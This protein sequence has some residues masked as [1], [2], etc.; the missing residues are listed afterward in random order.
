MQT[1]DVEVVAA[2][3]TAS[4]RSAYRGI[5]RDDF[6][7][8]DAPANRERHWRERLSVA[9]ATQTGLIAERAGRALGFAYLIADAD[10]ARGTLLDNLHVAPEARGDGIGRHLLSAVARVVDE[11]GWPAGLHLWVFAANT[12]ARRFYARHG[13]SEV[14]RRQLESSDGGQYEAVCCRWNDAAGLR[15]P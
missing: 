12:A 2:L 1:T 9:S 15:D 6:L 3:H 13:A 5:L 7:Q 4:W 11:R 8:Y 14:D 10:P